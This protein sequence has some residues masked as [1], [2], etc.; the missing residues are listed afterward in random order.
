MKFDLMQGQLRS[1]QLEFVSG[2]SLSEV[3]VAPLLC[4]GLE[5]ALRSVGLDY[6]RLGLERLC[7]WL[8]LVLAALETLCWL[9]SS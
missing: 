4:D 2:W 8:I 3:L 1:E 7:F 9:T 5:E 6:V